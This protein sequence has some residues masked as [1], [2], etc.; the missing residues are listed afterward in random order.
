MTIKGILDGKQVSTI[1]GMISGS[2]TKTQKEHAVALAM[3]CTGDVTRSGESYAFGDICCN[4][5]RSIESAA[6]A[7]CVYHKLDIGIPLV[8]V[9]RAPSN[10]EG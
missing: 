9:Q 8:Y 3:I 5:W 10:P 2:H 1:V 7:Y 4:G 6:L